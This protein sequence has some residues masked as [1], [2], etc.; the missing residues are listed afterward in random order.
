M[1]K[2]GAFKNI[3]GIHLVFTLVL[4]ANAVL[5]LAEADAQTMIEKPQIEYTANNLRDPFKNTLH[6][7]SEEARAAI[8]S[9]EETRMN[10]VL[11]PLVVAGLVWGGRHPQAII[12]DQVVMKGDFIEGAQVIEIEKEGVTV[13]YRNQTV[14]LSSPAATA[15]SGDNFS[16]AVTPAWGGNKEVA[17]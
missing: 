11:P 12:N 1:L 6:K 16:P 4:F 15:D 13:N 2:A 10:I 14:K 9:P 7:K 17:P 5:G 8:P 3:A